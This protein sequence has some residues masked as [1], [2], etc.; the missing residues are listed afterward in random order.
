MGQNFLRTINDRSRK[1]GETGYLNTI[2]LIRRSRQDLTEKNNFLFPFPD[3]DIVVVD[4]LPRVGEIAQLV[5]VS[6]KK[7]ATLNPVM[8]MFGNRPGN[9]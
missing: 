9:R 8:K 5:I 3:R 6:S 2:A 1:S 4:A 7:G